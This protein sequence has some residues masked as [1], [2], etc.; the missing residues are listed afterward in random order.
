MVRRSCS[1]YFE[2]VTKQIIECQE[3]NVRVVQDMHED[4]E[5]VVRCAIGD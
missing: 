5:T 3:T 2:D 4:S 1:V